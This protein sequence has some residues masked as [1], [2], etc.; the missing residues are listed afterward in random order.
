MIWFYFQQGE[1]LLQSTR[2]PPTGGRTRGSCRLASQQ[3]SPGHPWC[4][5]RCRQSCPG[6]ARASSNSEPDETGNPPHRSLSTHSSCSPPIWKTTLTPSQQ[7]NIP[8]HFTIR[9]NIFHIVP[10][11]SLNNSGLLKC[12][13]SGWYLGWHSLPMQKSWTGSG[14]VRASQYISW[15][16]TPS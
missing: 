5:G 9:T 12:L 7:F 8:S 4:R 14:L 10:F 6:P 3:V 16:S 1:S 11:H 13:C 15:T 2:P